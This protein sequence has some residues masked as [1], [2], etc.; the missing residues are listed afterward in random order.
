MNSFRCATRAS[1]PVTDPGYEMRLMPALASTPVNRLCA[2]SKP[3]AMRNAGAA[4]GRRSGRKRPV[5]SRIARN[6][7]T[8]GIGG[9]VPQASSG[10]TLQPWCL[11][12]HA[13]AREVPGPRPHRWIPRPNCDAG[14]WRIRCVEN[15][16]SRSRARPR[17][18]VWWRR[19]TVPFG[20]CA[21]HQGIR[22][23][24][25]LFWDPTSVSAATA[26]GADNDA[27]LAGFA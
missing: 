16:T 18:L 5:D 27:S 24:L 14:D 19:P 20:V 7:D 4:G 26:C 1:F 23:R 15:Q 6:G 21:E 10:E 12:A 25:G 11:W 2:G 3:Q 22:R 8:G 9:V 13:A 17:S